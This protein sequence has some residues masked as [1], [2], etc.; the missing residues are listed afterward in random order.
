[1]KWCVSCDG[2]K[3]FAALIVLATKSSRMATTQPRFVASDIVA[4]TAI[5]A[6]MILRLGYALDST[7]HKM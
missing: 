3:A 1:M 4:A 6:L 2:R 7:D 5:V